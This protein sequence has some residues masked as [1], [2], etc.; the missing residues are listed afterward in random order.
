MVDIRPATAADVPAVRE[1]VGAAYR[2]YVPRMGREPAPMTA[3]YAAIVAAGRAW[4]AEADGRLAGLVVLV[5][6]HLLLENVAVDPAQQGRGVGS[7]LLAFA[8][9]HARALG[10]PEVRLYTNEMMTENLAYYPRRGYVETHRT[11]EHGFNRVFFTKR[12]D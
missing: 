12:L 6:D 9:E 5:P 7:V 2:R 8:D 1:L 4:V 10:L 11:E 3:D